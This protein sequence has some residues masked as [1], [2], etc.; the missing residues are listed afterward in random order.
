MEKERRK[1]TRSNTVYEYE[2]KIAGMA[3]RKRT[4]SPTSLPDGTQRGVGR[5]TVARCLRLL[6]FGVDVGESSRGDR[7]PVNS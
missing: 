6:L 4:A 1:L 7:A 3:E 5:R 2:A